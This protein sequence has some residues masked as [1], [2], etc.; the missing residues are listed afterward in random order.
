LLLTQSGGVWTSARAPIAGLN[1]FSEPDI[2]PAAISCSGV[3]NCVA[4]GSYNGQGYQGGLILT[5]SGGSWSAQ[6]VGKTGLNVP[7]DPPADLADV[8]CV[9]T[10][11]CVAVGGYGDS[12]SNGHGLIET[13][14]NGSW[15]GTEVNLSGLSTA[16]DQSASLD[17]VACPSAG[18]CTAAGTY[19]DASAGNG[20]YQMIVV[21]ST[22]SSWGAAAKVALP[23]NADFDAGGGLRSAQSD[24]YA[25]SIACVSVGNCLVVGSYDATSAD[26][27]VALQLSQS[28]GVWA[29]G[30]E[31][32]LPG[33]AA[34][35]PDA[36]LGAAA[37]WAV[38]ACRAVGAY[39][40]SAGALNELVMSESS[41]SWSERPRPRF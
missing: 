6:P 37:C 8:S 16:A 17:T 35:D 29:A 40:T 15:T 11:N 1:A 7:S 33:D 2:Q 34:A 32:A 9:A 26:A 38:G 25:G 30:T 13:E 23:A 3:G 12:S 18:D 19:L 4:V 24:L 5:D 39:L 14:T 21:S 41:G 36:Q 28:G 20:S 27:E 31:P 22:N 10:G